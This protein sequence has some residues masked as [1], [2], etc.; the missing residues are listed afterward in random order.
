VPALIEG[1]APAQPQAR[2]SPPAGSA[3]ISAMAE[4]PIRIAVLG[5]G[6]WSR[7]QISGWH[8][9][10]GARVVALCN[11]TK[12]KALA[13]GKI[14]GIA[15]EHVYDD[16]EQLIERTMGGVDV[17]D[18]VT[19]VHTHAPFVHL[20][21][22][23]R[24]PVICQKPMA[25]D[26]ATARAMVAAC[27]DAGVPLYIHENWRWQTPLRALHEAISS[28]QIGPIHRAR[29]D[30]ISGFPVFKNQPFLAELEQFIITDLGSHTLDVARWMFGEVTSLYCQ[31]SQVHRSIKGEDAATIMMRTERGTTVV[32]NMAYA[33]N[34]IEH[35]R[36]PET[37]VFVEGERGSA[38]LGP[39]YWL[40]VTTDKGTLKRR[41]KPPR[42]GWADPEYDVVHSS[43]VDCNRD[44]L[45]ALRGQKTAETSGQDNLKTVELVFA[46]Y[47]S[48]ARNT[49]VEPAKL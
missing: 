26:L 5:T 23:H 38:Q 29:I 30:M 18:I 24:V 8:E 2:L 31:T 36:F 17:I 3:N 35:D 44:L 14:F 6:F 47:A 7:F 48:A 10:P 43:I 16:A 28:S 21:A 34:P 45:A 19:D 11:R 1:E 46:A 37:Y 41:C 42:Y 33:G 27:R 39:D 20:C 40:S 15:P 9:L 49:V 4:R 22:E 25:S 13:L 32:C 12:S